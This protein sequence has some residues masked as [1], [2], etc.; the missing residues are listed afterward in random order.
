M[1]IK[2]LTYV[3]GIFLIV[4]LLSCAKIPEPSA[5]YSFAMEELP[6]SDSIPLKWGELIAVSSTNLK[7]PGWVQLWF[8][9]KEGTIYMVPYDVEIRKFGQYYRYLKRR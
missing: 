7:Y 1:A 3:A 4:L 6:L 8:Q 9:D 2:T 5:G